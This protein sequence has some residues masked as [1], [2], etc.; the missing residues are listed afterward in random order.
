MHVGKLV[1]V[2]LMDHLPWKT[3]GRIVERYG[4]NHRVRDFSCVNQ[5]RCYRATKFLE[6]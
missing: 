6:Q 2:Q 3:I 5:Y 1:F 4:S